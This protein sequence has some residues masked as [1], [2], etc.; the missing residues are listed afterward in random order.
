MEINS[1][2]ICTVDREPEY[3]HQTLVRLLFTLK[4]K[5]EIY[6]VVDGSSYK[7]FAAYKD[8]CKIYLNKVDGRCDNN[9]K[10]AAVNYARCLTLSK[11]IG[12]FNL[13]LED[14]VLLLPDWQDK[15]KSID[16]E[17]E[18]WILSLNNL[19]NVDSK[20]DYEEFVITQEIPQRVW[21]QTFAT[22][23]SPKVLEDLS[24]DMLTFS[25]YKNLPYDLALG[26]VFF[27]KKYPVYELVP[28]FV[29]HLG[30]KSHMTV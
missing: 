14:D 1:I 30:L 5:K 29:E 4:E 11:N 10:K 28:S 17:E 21:C 24:E 23:Y 25:F 2:I 12:G 20:K 8:Y 26:A 15:L 6:L 16:L 7:H 9:V 22:I 19:Q 13:I 27:V 18:K 3:I